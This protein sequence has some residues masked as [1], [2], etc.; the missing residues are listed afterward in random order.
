MSHTSNNSSNSKAEAIVAAQA[1]A[2]S[3]MLPVTMSHNKKPAKFTRENFKTWQQ[4]M[5][6]YLT[7]LNMAKFLKDDPPI[8]RED[9]KDVVT[10]FN[11]AKAWNTFDFLCRNYIL[12]G[13]SNKLYEV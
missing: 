7:M 4:K 2:A 1:Q 8:F 13:L 10:T 3:Q 11:I 9:E 5:L 6:F 12:N